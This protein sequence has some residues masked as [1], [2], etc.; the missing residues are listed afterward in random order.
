MNCPN[1]QATLEADSLF[2]TSCGTKISEEAATTQAHEEHAVEATPTAPSAFVEKSKGMSK[3]YWRFLVP[4]IKRPFDSSKQTTD[5]QGDVANGLIT[6][7]LFAFLTALFPYVL[8]QVLYNGFFSPSFWNLT[9]KPFL[10]LLISMAIIIGVV[11][12]TMK[13]AQA[14]YSFLKVTTTFATLMVIPMLLTALANIAI[15]LGLHELSAYSVLL[16]VM[17]LSLSITATIVALAEA[18]PTKKR[19]DNFYSVVIVFVMLFIIFALMGEAMIEPLINNLI[20]DL[21]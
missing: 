6:L 20:G 14:P 10:I 4:A 1:C 19:I 12:L 18:T 5:S 17:L 2:C 21:F 16:A 9:F 3:A 7:I 8:N 11:F 15:I 13:L